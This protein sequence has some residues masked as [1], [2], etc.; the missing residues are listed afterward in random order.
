MALKRDVVRDRLL[1]LVDTLPAGSAL[2][3]ERLLAP[4]LGVSRM[5]LRSGLDELVRGGRLVRRHG[6][7][8]VVADTH[9]AP[10]PPLRMVSFA[11]DMRSRGL[12]P[13][14]RTLSLHRSPAGARIGRRLGVSPTAEVHAALRLRLADGA[15]M[16]LERMHVPV[17][18]VPA[19]DAA[20]LERVGLYEVLA[21]RYGLVL[22]GGTQTIEPTVLEAD[23]ADLLQVPVHAPALLFERTAHDRQG[24]RVEFVRSLFRGDR[25]KLAAD[26]VLP[27]RRTS[28][29]PVPRKQRA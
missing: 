9:G 6:R 19:L 29:I 17:A 23:E 25:Y 2:P 7:A 15:P 27:P 24:R 20:D 22:T 3:P 12:V 26:L 4:E 21:G 11:E 28:P 18:L 16:A 8:T 14:S 5:T 10:S 13:S 1:D